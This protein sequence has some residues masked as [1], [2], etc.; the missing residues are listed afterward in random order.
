MMT[1]A[2]CKPGL[3]P[4]PAENRQKLLMGTQ[5]RQAGKRMSPTA[6]DTT[7]PM[8]HFLNN[9][10]FYNLPKSPLKRKKRVQINYE[11]R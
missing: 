8:S 11:Q 1:S 7:E 3:D 10:L 6:N 4:G 5:F 2:V 9:I